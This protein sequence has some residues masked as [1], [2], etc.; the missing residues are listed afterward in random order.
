MGRQNGVIKGIRRLSTF[1]GGKIAVPMG[2][3]NR[4]PT[5][6]RWVQYLWGSSSHTS[7]VKLL[8]AVNTGKSDSL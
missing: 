5:L 4:H 6:R 8:K 3:D 2:A 7:N 1:G